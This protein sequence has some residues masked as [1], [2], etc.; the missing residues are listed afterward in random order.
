MVRFLITLVFLLALLSLPVMAQDLSST[1]AYLRVAG[2]SEAGPPRIMDDLVVFT[3][4]QRGYARYVAAAFA[5]ENFEKKH[6]FIARRRDD[7]PD[8]FYLAFPVDPA[9]KDLEYRLIV[10]GV[11][12]TD[13]HAPD[14]RRDPRGITLGRVE[15]PE[16]PPYREQSPIF[17]GDG[18]VTFRFSFELRMSPVLETVDQRQVSVANLDR[19]SISL[20]GSFNGWDPFMYHLRP[21]PARE[22]F[23]SVRVPLRP[24]D[25]FYYFLVDGERVLDPFNRVRARDSRT[26]TLVSAVSVPR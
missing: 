18:T 21:D 17:H 23:F 4:E 10:D 14:Y 12:L 24:G 3:Y 20:T 5:H 7:R 9:W 6:L 8:L 15:L 22:G 11:W 26:G 2:I 19:P 1:D 16:I 25:H 13:P